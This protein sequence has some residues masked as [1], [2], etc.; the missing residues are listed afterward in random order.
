MKLEKKNFSDFFFDLW[1]F[2]KVVREVDLQSRLRFSSDL[3]TAKYAARSCQVVINHP[4][5][6]TKPSRALQESRVTTG[7]CCRHVP[8][9]VI[10]S[11][12]GIQGIPRIPTCRN[13]YMYEIRFRDCE[14]G[15]LA[16]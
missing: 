9:L 4:D 6:A 2:R 8:A 7:T 5:N 12:V 1:R 3:V 15:K 13:S 11:K 16:A 10:S 14:I